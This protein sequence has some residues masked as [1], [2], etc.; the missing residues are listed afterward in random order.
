MEETISRNAGQLRLYSISCRS[1]AP[2]LNVRLATSLH[3][4]E[5]LYHEILH[6]ALGYEEFFEMMKA[7]ESRCEISPM[8]CMESLQAR[9]T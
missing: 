8:E 9:L 7:K 2:G 1:K 5:T 6:R 4:K 3:S